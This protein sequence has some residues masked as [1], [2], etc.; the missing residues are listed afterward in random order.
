MQC[1]LS[2]G[3]PPAGDYVDCEA[4]R[5]T[6]CKRETGTEELCEITWDYHIVSTTA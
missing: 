2:T 5:R 1:R 3:Y 6:C 4:E